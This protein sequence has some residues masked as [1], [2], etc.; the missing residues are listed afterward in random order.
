MGSKMRG[1]IIVIICLLHLTSFLTLNAQ[2]VRTYGGSEDDYPS[3]IL[4]TFDGGYIVAGTSLSFGYG[5]RNIW[6]LK[7]NSSGDVEWQKTYGVDNS[8][9]AYG[10]SNSILEGKFRKGAWEFNRVR[11]E[12]YD[13]VGDQ[14]VIVDTFT[15]SE[16]VRI[17]DR[18]NQL[19]DR[20]IDTTQKA[21]ARGGAYLRQAEI[22]SAGGAIRIPINCGQQ[23]YDVIDITDSRA[24]LS[25]EKK[26]VLGLILVYNTRRGEYDQRL[27]LGAV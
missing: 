13:P 7:F 6:I 26:R 2:W 24:G 4:Q 1:R 18:L 21:Q 10:S 14:P 17:Y 19:D 23:L 15:W 12:G 8:G 20:N 3:S 22:G 27:L 25:A 9:Y 16:I 11:V 5:Y